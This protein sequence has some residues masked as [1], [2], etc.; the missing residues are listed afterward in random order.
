MVVGETVHPEVNQD[1]EIEFLCFG[2]RWPGIAPDDG[3]AN[4]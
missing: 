1:H 3:T 4:L 2:I